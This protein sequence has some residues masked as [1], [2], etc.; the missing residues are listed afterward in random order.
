VPRPREG[1][2]LPRW[3]HFA[4]DADLGVRGVGRTLA[5]AFEQAAL[6]LAAAVVDP[7]KVAAATIVDVVCEAPTD[8]LLLVDWLNAIIFEMSTRDLCFGRFEVAIDSGRLMGRAFGEPLDAQKH[9]IGI[10]PKGATYTA[11]RV[12]LEPAGAWVAQCVVDV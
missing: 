12:G 5:E 4:H 3:E 11:L 2:A 7:A 6:A 8:E 1:R 10:E 9:D